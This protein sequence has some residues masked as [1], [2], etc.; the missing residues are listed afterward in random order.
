MAESRR[1]GWGWFLSEPG[2]A[3]ADYGA[4]LAASPVLLAS[5]R[6]DGHAV[7]V[8]PGFLAEDSSTATLRIFLRSRGYDVHGWRLGRNLGPTAAI[9][10]GMTACLTE[11]AARTER[12]VS[13]VGWSL[14][15]IF[16][17]E[18]ARAHPALVRQVVTLGSPFRLADSRDSRAH[19]AFQRYSRLHVDGATLPRREHLG[20][21]IGVPSTAIYSKHDGIVPWEACME[22]PG[23]YRENVAVYSSHLGLGHNAAALWVVADRLAQPVGVWRP[24]RAPAVARPLFPVAGGRRAA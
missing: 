23:H 22:L 2:R 21:P 12:P 10:S 5:P 13:L 9:L 19:A 8:L 1:P 3:V 20:R 6:G 17:R 18:L 16:A 4:L 15:G 7:L 14:G 24:F 11:M